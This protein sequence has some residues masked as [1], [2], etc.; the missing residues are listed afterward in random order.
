MLY[1]FLSGV[2]LFPVIFIRQLTIIF[3]FIF[4]FYLLLH[5]SSYF[6]KPYISFIL[7]DNLEIVTHWP[8]EPIQPLHYVGDLTNTIPIP[9]E[10]ILRGEGH[11]G[12]VSNGK[13]L[14]SLD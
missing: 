7:Y 14:L 10:Y 11:F 12:N 6:L 2:F 3:R 13:C 8:E 1:C 5:F 9:R 4:N